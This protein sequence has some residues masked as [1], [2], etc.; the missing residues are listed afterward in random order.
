MR[1]EMHHFFSTLEE[2][3]MIDVINT[4]WQNLRNSLPTLN[5]FEQLVEL[6]RDQLDFMM[7]KCFLQ[8][9]KTSR[10]VETL[11]KMC[12]FAFKICQMVKEHGVDVV[13]DLDARTELMEI[14]SSFNEYNRFLYQ[15]VKQLTEK[16]Q[17]RD[18]FLRLDYN[19]FLNKSN[20]N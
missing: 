13:R 11:N 12:N 3:I 16:G 17:F 1:R 10:V 6:H 9:G 5:T 19:R 20:S 8:R 4:A 7:E 15:L 2:Y 18:L 14:Q